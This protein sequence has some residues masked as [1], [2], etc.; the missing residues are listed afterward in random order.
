M[1]A[2]SPKLIVSRVDFKWQL[3]HCT[4]NFRFVVVHYAHL[5]NWVPGLERLGDSHRHM[6]PQQPGC[7]LPPSS[8]IAA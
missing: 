2:P 5:G 8:A 1:N 4:A 7:E 3:P 6:P